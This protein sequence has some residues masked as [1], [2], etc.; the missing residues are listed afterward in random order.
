M[1]K[2]LALARCVQTSVWVY[3]LRPALTYRRTRNGET[4]EQ[5]HRTAA[6]GVTTNTI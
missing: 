1:E 5:A 2:G 3:E 4:K 6:H